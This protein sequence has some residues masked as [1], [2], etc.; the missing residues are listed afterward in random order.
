VP[1]P[2][3]ESGSPAAE[4]RPG[5]SASLPCCN[6]IEQPDLTALRCGGTMRRGLLEFVCDTCGARCGC[7]VHPLHVLVEDRDVTCPPVPVEPGPNAIGE[8]PRP[9]PGYCQN[10]GAELDPADRTYCPVCGADD[11]DDD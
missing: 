2:D 9:W 6:D 7:L 1:G 4:R 8:N 3:I 5:A 11:I 10:C